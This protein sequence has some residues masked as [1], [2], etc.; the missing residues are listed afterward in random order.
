MTKTLT[1]VLTE[2]RYVP[3]AEARE[4]VREV[5]C[6]C[7]WIGPFAEVADHL[8]VVVRMW[9]FGLV[10]DEAVVAQ[11]RAAADDARPF[12]SKWAHSADAAIVEFVMKSMGLSK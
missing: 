11:W 1:Q 7:G 9:V 8:S 3:T 5:E 10:G 12:M 2:H 4:P 6:A